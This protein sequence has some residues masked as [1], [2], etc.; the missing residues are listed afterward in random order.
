[1]KKIIIHGANIGH[2]MKKSVPVQTQP[3]VENSDTMVENQPKVESAVEKPLGG[4]EGGTGEGEFI[5]H[6]VES[7][8]KA[9]RDKKKTIPIQNKPAE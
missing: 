4:N 6:A 5:N 1:M 8:W 9:K 3:I 2:V 7:G